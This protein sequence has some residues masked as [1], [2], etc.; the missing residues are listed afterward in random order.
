MGMFVRLSMSS[1]LRTVVSRFT[2]MKITSAGRIRPK[3][4]AAIIV[5]RLLGNVGSMLPWGMSM[6]CVGMEA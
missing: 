3:R 4:M 6:T 1:L 2:F 5:L